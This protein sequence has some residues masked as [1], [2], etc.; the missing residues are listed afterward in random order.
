MS[1]RIVHLVLGL[2]A[3]AL[4][5]SACTR[6]QPPIYEPGTLGIVR[7]TSLFRAVVAGI[8]YIEVRGGMVVS[9]SSVP[10]SHL[11]PESRTERERTLKGM[12]IPLVSDS[13]WTLCRSSQRKQVDR[14]RWCTT[15]VNLV[16]IGPPRT[17]GAFMAGTVANDSAALQVPNHETSRVFIRGPAS[18]TSYDVVARRTGTRWLII[19][20]VPLIVADYFPLSR[21]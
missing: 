1:H 4:G 5:A 13:A 2:T 6:H 3:M 10:G 20:F 17:G 19:G 14:P 15:D 7:D 16:T 18:E 21:P 8:P 11:T 9:E 12:G